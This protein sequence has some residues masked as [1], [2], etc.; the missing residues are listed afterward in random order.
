[1]FWPPKRHCLVEF[2]GRKEWRS[3]VSG[4]D[5]LSRQLRGARA[6]GEGEPA[7][8]TYDAMMT[9]LSICRSVQ[10][11][12]DFGCDDVAYLSSCCAAHSIYVVEQRYTQD[13]IDS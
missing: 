3:R 10:H 5:A 11:G 8:P 1:M 7:V 12:A 9:Y 2:S 4:G 6:N 13:G